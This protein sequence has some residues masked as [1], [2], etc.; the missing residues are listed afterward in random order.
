MFRI[1]P[2]VPSFCLTLTAVVWLSGCSRGRSAGGQGGDL[3]V[4]RTVPA[5]AA[6]VFLN[7]SLK[8][9]VSHPLDPDSVDFNAV[10]F[11]VF[12][13][14]G[15]ALAES[16]EGSFRVARSDTDEVS[17]RRLEFLPKF[18][19][20]DSLDD[21]GFKPAR[22]YV[23]QLVRGDHR[24]GVGLVDTRGK[25]LASPVSFT[26]QTVEGTSTAQLFR[27]T[28]PGG[29]RLVSLEVTPLDASGAVERNEL[30]QH[31]VEF[32]LRFDQ[33]LNPHSS[34]LPLRADLDARLRDPARR[35]RVWLEYDDVTGPTWIPSAVQLTSNTLEGAEL[36]LR[37]LGVLPNHA[38]V[39]VVATPEL[40][41]LSGESNTD[42]ATYDPV[43][44]RVQTAPGYEL[45]FDGLV[46]RFLDPRHIDLEA[47]FVEPLADTL[48]GAIRASF[49]FEGGK[50]V[51]D[52]APNSQEVVLDT[53]FTQITPLNGQPINVSGGVFQ[54][55]NVRIP[56]GVVVRGVGSR[57]MVWLVTGD[58]V[59]EGD[60]LVEG[61]DGM[62]VN[63]IFSANI[64]AGGGVGYCGAGNGGQGSPQ[65]SLRSLR[66]QAGFGPDQ[67][68]EGGGAGG[69]INCAN[70]SC[71]RGSGGGGGSFATRGDPYYKVAST[72][73]FVQPN[74]TGGFGCSSR[75][76]TALPGGAA[77]PV[78][79]LDS[80]RDNDFWGS[81][82]DLHRRLRITGELSRPL[83]GAG[84][85]GGGDWGAACTPNDPNFF[86]DQKGG[87]G[88]AG[89][90]VL[91][92]KA[93]GSIVIKRTGR[94]S[95]DGG[96]G[97]GGAY[98]GANSLCG[99][100]GGGSGGMVVLMAGRVIEIET[101]GETY[102]NNDYS[103]AITADGG[104]G[105]SSTINGKYSPAPH[106]ASATTLNST[107]TG[108]FGGSGIV[109]LMAPP[110]PDPSGDDAT[111][112]LLDDFII[113]RDANGSVLRGAQKER[114]LGWRGFPD[115][116][117]GYHDDNGAPVTLGKALG[118]VTPAPVLLPA[119]FGTR[120]RVRSKWIDLG[121]AD[122]RV[123]P[124]GGDGKA[125]GVAVPS[126]FGSTFGPL[127][128][129]HGVIT[130]DAQDPRAGYTLV[131]NDGF[132]GVAI[133]Y[134][135]LVSGAA[136]ASIE[137]GVAYRGQR[138]SVV[139]LTAP[140]L[141]GEAQRFTQHVA[142]LRSGATTIGEFRILGHEAD[143][144]YVS[145][146]FGS[147]AEVS[148]N[149]SG[150]PELDVVAKLY[151]VFTGTREGFP[152]VF[153]GGSSGQ[154][155]PRQ[156]V[157]IGF[158]FHQD[159]RDPSAERFPA[160]EGTFFADW[161]NAAAVEQLRQGGFRFVQ[162]DVLFDLRY[163]E[164]PAHP[165]DLTPG[166]DSPRPEL[167][168]LVLPFRY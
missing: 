72:A 139:R 75:S 32:R 143:L 91:I 93:L 160:A 60:L 138:V 80:R 67:V 108:G 163:E 112:T 97:G 164:S 90:G 27:D 83:G 136:V 22:R 102:A 101:H 118:D 134:P 15:N 65:T 28:L 11:A 140:S 44:G 61:G 19:T 165:N 53:D 147:P 124:P 39:R 154:L 8:I 79:F 1:R 95:A 121:A 52:Y 100:G 119:P 152:D 55:R 42:N 94:I 78:A 16:V 64:P 88:G 51:L 5:N 128:E 104:V 159:P 70:A 86:N 167:R 25:G 107:S 45:R 40:E 157:R 47:P 18:A 74:G 141:A 73:F 62:R 156:N 89:G 129:F 20:T 56:R 132:G 155:L 81:A 117:G 162:Y 76:S 158:A 3:L 149:S 150:K 96:N 111:H 148:V 2:V 66:G 133:E 4:L 38:E 99:G 48:P 137:N 109:Q 6:T 37:P 12:D 168:S 58:F 9:D 35:G 105:S 34:N 21:G 110:G 142:R 17:G 68:P 43:V 113:I 92:V 146:E 26:F 33:P 120:S 87:G 36:V 14:Q 85:G 71:G 151:S 63:T 82:V 13:L 10:S 130:G 106:S 30:G 135:V 59:V 122:R 46:E 31:P 144:L 29:P 123:T 115:G 125:R 50:T 153:L 145:E 103:F 161:D 24:A 41:D 166:P 127:P 69:R 57:P 84:G 7:D 98:A 126:S 114:Y 23:V 49:A 54:F 131:K 77:G 116:S